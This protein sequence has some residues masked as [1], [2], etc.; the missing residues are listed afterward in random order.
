MRLGIWSGYFPLVKPEAQEFITMAKRLLQST[1]AML[2]SAPDAVSQVRNV[3][4]IT[5]IAQA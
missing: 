5:E 1:E 3:E 4:K 2:Q